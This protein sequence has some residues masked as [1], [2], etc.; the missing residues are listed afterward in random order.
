MEK[1]STQQEIL[2]V[3]GT[4]FSRQLSENNT[5]DNLNNS[6]QLEKE[7]WNGLLKELLPEILEKTPAGKEL[8][9]WQIVEAD[10]FIELDLGE[11][12]QPIEKNGSINPYS[13]LL[14]QFY[15]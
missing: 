1:I 7:C 5:A 4:K 13:F 10:S 2:L 12:P 8:Y 14:T 15:N 9:L 6:E 11:Y 3:T